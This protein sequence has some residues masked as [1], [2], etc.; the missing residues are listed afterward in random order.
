MYS[1]VILSFHVVT[2]GLERQLNFE[3][4]RYMVLSEGSRVPGT[5]TENPIVLGLSSSYEVRSFASRQ[6]GPLP[7]FAVYNPRH[8][9]LPLQ[10]SGRHARRSI[11]LEID[12]LGD[13]KRL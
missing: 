10:C 3:R 8:F 4:P 11:E 7:S 1:F 13:F 9:E 12:Q 6:L 5:E 2:C